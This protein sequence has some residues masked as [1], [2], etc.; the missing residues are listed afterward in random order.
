MDVEQTTKTVLSKV[1]G[2]RLSTQSFDE[3]IL[4]VGPP[5]QN[6]YGRLGQ[7]VSLCN[8]LVAEPVDHH[9]LQNL[10]FEISLDLCS[11]PSYC[12]TVKLLLDWIS[13]PFP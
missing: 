5:G 10:Q 3:S 1:I 11:R 8:N 2:F 13:F 9:L 4:L 12:S 7:A 6:A